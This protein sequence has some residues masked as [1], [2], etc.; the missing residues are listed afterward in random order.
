MKFQAKG[1]VTHFPF[2]LVK[3]IADVRR[4]F[5]ITHLGFG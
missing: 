5:H 3:Y 2:L 1:K 4:E